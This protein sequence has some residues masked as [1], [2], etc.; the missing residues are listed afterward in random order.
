MVNGDDAEV[1]RWSGWPVGCGGVWGVG[2]WGSLWGGAEGDLLVM[3]NG[4]GGEVARW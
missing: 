1:V 3:V 2:W 4:D